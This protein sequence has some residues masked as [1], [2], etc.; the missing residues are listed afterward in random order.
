MTGKNANIISSPK[1]LSIV[2]SETEI[3]SAE[4]QYFEEKIREIQKKKPL[5]SKE[6]AKK[7][8]STIPERV[9]RERMNEE[10]GVLIIYLFDS[11]YSFNQEV[12]KKEDTEFKKYVDEQSID[13]N[14]PL[15][16]YAIGFPPIEKDP[17]GIYVQGDY[18]LVQDEG[19]EEECA[20][21]DSSLPNDI[22]EDGN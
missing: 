1:D 7:E 8:I 19:F 3:E 21:E 22:Q 18:D 5:L 4:N 17:G 14:I 12:G 10:N 13:L 15:V 6:D 20:E 2:L 11:H 9:Y 16:G